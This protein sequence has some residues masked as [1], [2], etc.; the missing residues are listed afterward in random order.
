MPA[1][2]R[3]SAIRP[4]TSRSR[5]ESAASGS[6]RRGA[7][8]TISAT[9]AGSMTDAAAGHRARR[10]HELVDPGDAALQQVAHAPPEASSSLAC[11]T[12]TWAESTRMPTSGARPGCGGR[13]R[14]PRRRGRGGMRMS[15]T[16][17]S[18]RR[19]VDERHQPL[20]VADL[21]DDLEA[22][23]APAGRPAPRAAARRRRPAPRAWT[24]CCP[25]DGRFQREGHERRARGEVEHA[26][27]AGRGAVD[28]HAREPDHLV[29][30]ARRAA[31][32][33]SRR[34]S[35]RRTDA[36]RRPGRAAAGCPRRARRGTRRAGDGAGAPAPAPAGRRP[37]PGRAP[38]CAARSPPWAGAPP[39][40][41]WPAAP[42]GG[43]A[44]LGG[45]SRPAPGRP[46]PRARGSGRTPAAARRRRA[47]PVPA[48]PGRAPPVA[49]WRRA[50]R[51]PT[52]GR[53]RWRGSR[54]AARRPPTGRRRPAT[55]H[56]GGGAQL[57]RARAHRRDVE[58]G[59]V[60]GHGTG[61]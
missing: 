5:A 56:R 25:R 60:V 53:R 52:G 23:G 8:A 39:P 2:E 38:G 40:P 1:F 27:G 46:R 22:R 24:S 41:G 59:Q 37:R 16:T 55:S 3:P 49:G 45:R 48:A 10:L 13:P 50:A 11:S 58:V 43:G 42:R 18:G 20:A 51:A 6:C 31:R 14:A 35:A 32:R 26:Q 29:E 4:S 21:P 44:R 17:R 12:S 28:G 47:R 15:V 54:R 7:A 57:G 9:S 34:P 36:R 30:L 61:R 19:R 33:R